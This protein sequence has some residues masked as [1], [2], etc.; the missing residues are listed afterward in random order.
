[1]KLKTA[2]GLFKEGFY[3]MLKNRLVSIVAISTVFI[4][5]SIFGIVYMFIN[6]VN[7]NINNM[8]GEVEVVAFLDE[9]IEKSEVASLQK[10]I[11][12]MD[13]VKSVE[14]VSSEE[15]LKEYNE[16]LSTQGDTEMA[17]ILNE[18]VEETKNPIPASFS[19]KTV[20]PTKNEE[21]KENVD[22]LEAIYKV[23]D[24]SVITSFLQK[25]SKYTKIIGGA[26]IIGLVVAS[27]L[28]I[29]N[30]IKVAIFVRKKEISIIKYIGA[31]NNY[32]RLP[33][34][35]EGFLIGTIG[36]LLS[37][38]VISIIYYSATG[39]ITNVLSQMISGFVMPSL[40][41]LLILLVPI[42]ILIGSGIGILGSLISIRKYLKV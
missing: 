19:I 41:S 26:F 35:M 14:Y 18:V 37:A 29:S 16:S 15:G 12:N 25:F 23:N 42:M 33:F 39:T 30:S 7:E 6:I 21:V 38:G 31:T 10:E 13:N 1:M 5:L 32:I 8:Q 20:E 17:Q 24:S 22:S 9:N 34:I 36:A 11:E 4:S 3:N 27:V 40:S 2:T 28:L